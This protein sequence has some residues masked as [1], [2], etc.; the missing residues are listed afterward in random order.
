MCISV[1]DKVLMQYSTLGDRLLS[2]VT[3]VL[4]GEYIIVYSPV[5]ATAVYRLKKNN[6]AVIK[7]VSE[8]LLKG[9]KTHVL[10]ELKAGD[11][12][13]RLAYPKEEVEVEMRKEPRCPC[14]FPA[15]L[16]VDGQFYEAHV[17]DMSSSAFRIRFH[18]PAVSMNGGLDSSEASL[19]F[20]IFEPTN[21]YRVDCTILKAFMKDHEKFAVLKING[22]QEIREKIAHYVATQCRGGFLDDV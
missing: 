7:Y 12:L 3:D 6:T 21:T 10:G 5:S 1:G 2:V 13:I 14:C 4:E 15:M 22:N 8:G 16:E 20:F 9:L 18:D 19:E 17:A 11:E